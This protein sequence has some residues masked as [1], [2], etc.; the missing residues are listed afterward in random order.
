M[1]E[2]NSNYLCAYGNNDF[3]WL[4]AE[5]YHGNSSWVDPF[6][7]DEN[8]ETDSWAN[9]S[10]KYDGCLASGLEGDGDRVGMPRSDNDKNLAFYNADEASSMRTKGG[11]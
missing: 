5:Q 7:A 9:R 8:N 1:S 6:N 2:C 4:I 11:C 3:K 10:T